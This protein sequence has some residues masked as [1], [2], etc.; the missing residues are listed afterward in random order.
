M[1]GR[2]RQLQILRYFPPPYRNPM[3]GDELTAAFRERN[4]VHDQM[5]SWRITT[6][7]YE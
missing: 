4:I 1:I 2:V 5:A 3:Y 7:A 6:W